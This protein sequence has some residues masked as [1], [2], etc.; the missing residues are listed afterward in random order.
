[1]MPNMPSEDTIKIWEKLLE[2]KMFHDG[3]HQERLKNFMLIEATIMIGFVVVLGQVFVS[4]LILPQFVFLVLGSCL[5]IMGFLLARRTSALDKR[6]E[7]N[8]VHLNHKIH[9]LEAMLPTVQ[10]AAKRHHPQ[11]NARVRRK[12]QGRS[13]LSRLLHLG[14]HRGRKHLLK[15]GRP[16]RLLIRA[17]ALAWAVAFLCMVGV[18]LVMLTPDWNVA[19]IKLSQHA[20]SKA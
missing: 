1:M 7:R 15:I 5:C 13:F 3:T 12:H 9:D 18:M 4:R 8:V 11:A 17:T 20:V 6:T 2:L 14:V 10:A 19:M 16:D